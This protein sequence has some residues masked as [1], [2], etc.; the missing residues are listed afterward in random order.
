MR[1]RPNLQVNLYVAQSSL[2]FIIPLRISDSFSPVIHA[3]QLKLK[4]KE[5]ILELTLKDTD[6]FEKLRNKTMER[7]EIF[8][9]KEFHFEHNKI[10]MDAEKLADLRTY[11]VATSR[12]PLEIAV[13]C[14]CIG[15]SDYKKEDAFLRTENILKVE[16]GPNDPTFE[17]DDFQVEA[18]TAQIAHALQDIMNKK[19]LYGPINK[20]CEAS[21]REFVSPVLSLA[22]LI[23][24]DIKMRAEQKI[25][26]LRGNGPLD[27]LFL[28]KKFP[29]TLTEVK[30]DNIE[31]G[32]AQ[33]DAQLVASRQEY[34]FHLQDYVPEL[35]EV[36]KKR[37]YLA[38]DIK[39]IPS[40]GI[41]SS[42]RDW[43]LQKLVVG[44]D[45][46]S[47]IYKSSVKTINLLDASEA[48]IEKQMLEVVRHIVWILQRQKESVDQHQ[49]AKRVRNE[50]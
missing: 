38:I 2:L 32:V 15:F 30:D 48:D 50:L 41:I 19:E 12:S 45:G 20:T 42:G 3:I 1:E 33:N 5:G 27:Y 7:W 35:K 36:S 6:S 29:V 8:Y 9:T 22:A 14:D 39:S 31:G 49:F 23:T 44:A 17:K 21:V 24:R 28:Y 40:F 10:E 4:Y 47:T 43:M 46:Q 18:Y 37:K 11:F 13:V 26:G 34:L 25:S 16:G